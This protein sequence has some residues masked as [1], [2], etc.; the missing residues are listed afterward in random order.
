MRPGRARSIL[1]RE[2]Y[3]QRL[4]ERAIVDAV[5]RPTARASNCARGIPAST[6]TST[7]AP[8][9]LAISRAVIGTLSATSEPSVPPPASGGRN[10]IPQLVWIGYGSQFVVASPVTSVPGMSAPVPSLMNWPAEPTRSLTLSLSLLARPGSPMVWT[11]PVRVGSVSSAHV[12]AAMS[13]CTTQLPSYAK[14]PPPKSSIEP[15]EPSVGA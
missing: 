2:E 12:R 3:A 9:G 7:N 15:R 11:V 8:L 1:D 13:Y 6:A 10:V 5:A 4:V 14:C